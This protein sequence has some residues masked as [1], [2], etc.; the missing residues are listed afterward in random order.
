MSNT[1][2]A[3]TEDAYAERWRLLM[4]ANTASNRKAAT[5][6][7]IVLTLVMTALA[8]ALVLQLLSSPA[9]A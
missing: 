7:R 1:T 6:E 4:L 2:I 8:A 5:R 9:W 3:E